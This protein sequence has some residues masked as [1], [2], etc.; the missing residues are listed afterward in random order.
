MNVETSAASEQPLAAALAAAPG[1]VELTT[2]PLRA[3]AD[4]ARLVALSPF[5]R[6]APQ[7]DGHPVL[8][9]PGFLAEDWTT[10]PMR[11]YL[12]SLGYPAYRWRLGRNIGPTDD[13]VSGIEWSVKRL[14]EMHGTKVTLIGWSL[15]GVMAR[16]VSRTAPDAIRQVITLGSPFGMEDPRQSRIS[17]V[18]A[19]YLDYHAEQ[20]RFG[21]TFVPSREPLAVPSTTIYTRSDGIVAW[22]TCVQRVDRHSE[23]IEVTGAHCGLGHNAAAL[24]AIGDRLAEPDDGWRPFRPPT[25]VRRWY[26]KAVKG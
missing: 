5:L 15:G 24:L 4:L 20:C 26:P 16:E 22:H 19:R 12:R 11:T 13:V 1:L 17:N 8:V 9:V 18:Y 14:S 3:A 21:V 23:N 2:E 10:V 7:G 25:I 6:L